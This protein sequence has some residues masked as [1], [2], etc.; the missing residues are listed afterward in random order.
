MSDN[1]F[2]RSVLDWFDKHGRHDLPWQTNTT[3]YHIWVSEI[4][5]QQTQ[6]RTV[7][8]YYQRFISRFSDVQSLANAGI[9]EVLHYWTGLGYY[10]RGRNLHKA[11]GVI[12]NEFNGEFP[13]VIEQL[14]SL[15]GI[16]RSTAG[17]ILA[18]GFNQRQPILDGN[19][20]RVLTRVYAIDGWPGNARVEK[21]LWALAEKLTP[22]QRV[23][24]YTQAMMDLGATLCTR[25][26]PDCQCC[27]IVKSCMAHA[28]GKVKDYPQQKPKVTKPV[29]PV[30]FLLLENDYGECL[31]QYRPPAGL[32][33]G[34]WGFPEC[35]HES[36][37]DATIEHLGFKTQYRQR[38]K[39]VRHTFSHFHLDINPVHCQVVASTNRINDNTNTC[40]YRPDGSSQLGMAAPVKKLLE[41][42]EFFNDANSTLRKTG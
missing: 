37:I 3:P 12:C 39:P 30:I 36:G 18:L 29:R 5:L 6:V 33:G 10:A 25:S 24:D 17:A 4:M 1:V 9:D 13:D 32:W 26:K 2:A 11:A 40:W 34:L 7:I 16:G 31:L 41:T 21:K 15:P 42:M 38:L 8:P 35:D 28:Q 20:K 27:P 23:A 14:I 19:V 22:C